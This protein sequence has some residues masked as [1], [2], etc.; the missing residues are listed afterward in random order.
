VSGPCLLF[1]ID[2]TL[3]SVGG[4]GRRAMGQAMEEVWGI[5]DPLDGIEFAGATDSGVAARIGPD[6]DAGRMWDRYCARLARML[7]SGDAPHPLPGVEALL[8]ALHGSGARLG[9][10]SG[11]LRRGAELKLRACGLA[12]RFDWS[13]SAFAEDGIERSALAEA[14]RARCDGAR[15]TVI[16]DSVPD[17][18]C[19]RHIGARVLAVATGPH[20]ARALRAA[21]PDRLV[22][23]LTA[24]EDLAAWLLARP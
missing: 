20:G 16:G 2:G 7:A 5:P 18:L 4:V 3:V 8:D 12:A 6:L 21:G 19:A 15:I 10:L 17:V 13:I 14:A 11:N 23:D 22:A 1:D 9:L 24:T